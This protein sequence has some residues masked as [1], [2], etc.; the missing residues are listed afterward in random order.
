MNCKTLVVVA[1]FAAFA[2]A[3]PACDR[4]PSDYD[5]GSADGERYDQNVDEPIFRVVTLAPAITQMMNDLG[6]QKM[7]AATA[8]QDPVAP[9]GLPTVGNYLDIHTESLWSVKPTH[10]L[11]MTDKAGVPPRLQEMADSG[12]FQLVTYPSPTK[13]S[14][15]LQIIYDYQEA[16]PLGEP[17]GPP[18][19]L[20]IIL[21]APA[22][23]LELHTT[24]GVQLAQLSD[25]TSKEDWP[26]VLMVIGTDPLMASG[27]GTVHDQLLSFIGG[28]NAAGDATVSAPVYDKEKIIAA[29]P[30]VI[31]LLEPGGAD[32]ESIRTDSRLLSFRGLPVPAVED[33]RIA[34]INDPTAL[35]PSSSLARVCASMAKVIHPNLAEQV[36]QAMST[37]LL[38]QREPDADEPALDD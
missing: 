38:P 9:D 36:D 19:S 25:L 8:D 7:I 37:G 27:P 20:G 16:F 14:D 2:M 13:V 23:A 17:T 24:I 29:Q 11:M 18:K 22:K 12:K 5:Y 32:L 28:V 1:L 34:V 31:L 3:T 4:P 6:L 33:G 10:V 35:L 30:D 26:R 21:S 15:I